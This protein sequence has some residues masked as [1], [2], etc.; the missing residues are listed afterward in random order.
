MN[1]LVLIIQI[2]LFYGGLMGMY[3]WFGRKGVMAWSILATVSA[4]IECLIQID[5]FGM[6]MTGGNI[7][8]ASTFLA[9]DII[10][11]MY[12]RKQANN[13]V[14]INVV[15]SVLFVL[16]SQS[17]LFFH[18]NSVDF[19]FPHVQGIFA[20][21]PRIMVASLLTYAIVQKADIYLYHWV[22]QLTTRKTDQ[23]GR[24]L[25]LRNNTATII[26]QFFNAVLFNFG[27]FFALTPEY[28][29]AYCWKISLA[30][31]VV[32]VATA[33]LDTP[34]IYGARKMAKNGK[35]REMDL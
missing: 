30:T 18:P 11:E 9:T 3:R 16:I 24:F 10:S 5:A 26:S 7:L 32:Y 12:G 14:H 28:T 25:W 1:E 13:L 35:V 33:L 19:V 15:I 8:F 34:F 4:N 21:V 20:S 23:K 31:F 17:W 2:L 27:A 22:W 29:A 6:S